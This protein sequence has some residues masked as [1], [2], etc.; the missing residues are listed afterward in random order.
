MA[1]IETV[2]GLCCRNA[3]AVVA[4]FVLAAL[5]AGFY[6]AE[7]FKMDTDS[8]KLISPKLDWRKR[9]ARFDALFPQQG[10]LILVVID[11]ATPELA[12]ARAGLAGRKAWRA[13]KAVSDRAPA[14]RRAVLSAERLAVSSAKPR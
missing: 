12:R 1:F 13:E 9:E 11:G 10:N 14:G 8:A 3:R 6:T 4:G 2:V 5:A 7:H